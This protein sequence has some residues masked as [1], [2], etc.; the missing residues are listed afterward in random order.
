MPHI[1]QPLQLNILSIKVKK[2]KKLFFLF[3][4]KV[5]DYPQT[6]K[7]KNQFSPPPPPFLEEGGGG[8]LPQISGMTPLD[9]KFYHS[10]QALTLKGG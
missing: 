5:M 8:S 4:F 10:F 3:V 2:H 9:E 7:K 1:E 6:S